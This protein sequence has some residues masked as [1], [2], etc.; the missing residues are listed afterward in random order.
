MP[1][2]HIS[3]WCG[4][5]C[6][7]VHLS[8]EIALYVCV[9]VLATA[10]L[11]SI[12][13]APSLPLP[14]SPQEKLEIV[15]TVYD[16]DGTVSIGRSSDVVDNILISLDTSEYF[17]HA[18]T[19][20]DTMTYS[21]NISRVQLSFRLTCYKDGYDRQNCSETGNLPSLAMTCVYGEVVCACHIC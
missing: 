5:W 4:V 21:G 12:A 20:S 18:D 19:F 7:H 13:T 6:V 3:S 11:G 16:L 2:V 10:K 14:L 9:H 17:L 1:T 8:Y 15:F